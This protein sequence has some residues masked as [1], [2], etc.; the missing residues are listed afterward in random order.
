MRIRNYLTNN[1]KFY[2]GIRPDYG[3]IHAVGCTRLRGAVASLLV[4]MGVCMYSYQERVE[5]EVDRQLL[6]AEAKISNL[7]SVIGLMVMYRFPME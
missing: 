1:G 7:V 6:A 4:F 5:Q 2:A 3:K